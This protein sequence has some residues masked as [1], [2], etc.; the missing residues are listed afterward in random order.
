MGSENRTANPFNSCPLAPFYPFGFLPSDIPCEYQS[1][2]ECQFFFFFFFFFVSLFCIFEKTCY[3]YLLYLNHR[4][5]FCVFLPK[6]LAR[7]LLFNRRGKVSFFPHDQD[8]N[9]HNSH[10]T[11]NKPKEQSNE[12]NQD[13]RT[14]LPGLP[15]HPDDVEQSNFGGYFHIR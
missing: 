12:Q 14:G 11:T 5:R 4:R 9:E 3:F 8:E 6:I 15:C 2:I 7:I 1:L 10:N 13:K